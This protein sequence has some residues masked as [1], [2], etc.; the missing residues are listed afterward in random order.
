MF[1]VSQSTVLLACA[2]ASNFLN[3]KAA[4]GS[5]T[6]AQC[7]GAGAAYT[8]WLPCTPPDVCIWYNDYYAQCLPP[9]YPTPTFITIKSTP[10]LTTVRRTSTT[11][12]ITKPTTRAITRTFT[13]TTSKATATA[14]CTP[15]TGGGVGLPITN[16]ITA[17]DLVGYLNQ[18]TNGAAIIS[19]NIWITRIGYTT[20]ATGGPITFN[21]SPT[22]YL[23]VDELYSASYKPLVLTTTL[24]TDY[25]VV[26]PGSMTPGVGPIT[27]SATS[28]YGVKSIFLACGSNRQLYLQTGN[29]T[30]PAS[31][32]CQKTGLTM[33]TFY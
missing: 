28:P 22:L 14:K 32:A 20:A 21:C 12:P 15:A 13:W 30:P 25:W 5:P 9:D 29:D 19:D 11:S 31:W 4:F 18:L 16:A 24:H 26:T 1:T 17:T 6:F 2:L 8:E 27:T 7:G 33:Q 3:V 10:A 23:S